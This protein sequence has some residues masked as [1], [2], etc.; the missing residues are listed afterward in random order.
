[1]KQLSLI[2]TMALIFTLSACSG[3]GGTITG[4]KVINSQIATGNI[5]KFEKVKPFTETIYAISPPGQGFQQMFGT[6][7]KGAF[8]Y[9]SD[10]EYNTLQS[11]ISK[12]QCPASFLNSHKNFMLIISNNANITSGL[13]SIKQG[14][15][16]YVD[17]FETNFV[18]LYDNTGNKI[19]FKFSGG[20]FKNQKFVYVDKISINDKYYI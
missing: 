17:G 19:N 11:L 1:M 10:S 4:E 20:G 8:M 14:D 9:C 13:S 15:K 2:L 12:G 7:V 18:G 5:A 3:T 6:S 16:V